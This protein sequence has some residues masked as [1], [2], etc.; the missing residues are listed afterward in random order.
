M[1]VAVVGRRVGDVAAAA[2]NAGAFSQ[3]LACG[4]SCEQAS[5]FGAARRFG[6]L[7]D[8]SEVGEHGGG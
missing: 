2:P 4:F 7:C 5:A 8:D 1:C 6:T 3:S